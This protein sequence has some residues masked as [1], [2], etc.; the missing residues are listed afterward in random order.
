M[1]KSQ[2]QPTMAAPDKQRERRVV[3]L[4]H[5]TLGLFLTQLNLA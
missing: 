3:S 4:G 2:S 5:G 1:E